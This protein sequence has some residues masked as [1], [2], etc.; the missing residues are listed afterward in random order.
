MYDG[1]DKPLF[2]E[3]RPRVGTVYISANLFSRK[4]KFGLRAF[5]Q[6][7]SFVHVNYVE[8]NN[9]DVMFEI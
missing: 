3:A 5:V 6:V 2:G 7:T 8:S 9:V 1:L 4:R